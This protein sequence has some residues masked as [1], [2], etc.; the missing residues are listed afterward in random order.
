MRASRAAAIGRVAGSF[1]HL[2]DRAAH[3]A[4]AAGDRVSVSGS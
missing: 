1:L 2:I 3:R 4:A